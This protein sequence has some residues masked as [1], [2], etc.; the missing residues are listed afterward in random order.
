MIPIMIGL[1]IGVVG[2]FWC[3][4]VEWIAKKLVG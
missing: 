3:F 2:V 4:I 1:V